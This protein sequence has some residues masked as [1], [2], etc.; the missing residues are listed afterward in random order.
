MVKWQNVLYR[1]VKNSKTGGSDGTVD[2]LLKL[3]G[4]GMVDLLEQ[5]FS[6]IWQGE[7]VSI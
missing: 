4:L 2:K 3:G 7:I 6:V 1:K 5:L